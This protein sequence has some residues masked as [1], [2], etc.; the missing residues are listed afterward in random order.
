MQSNRRF[1]NG[2][3]VALPAFHLGMTTRR[4]LTMAV[5]GGRYAVCRLPADSPVP[6]WASEGW[7]GSEFCS[8]TRTPDELSIICPEARTPADVQAE[9]GFRVLKVEG[10]LAFSE[11]GIIAGIAV[12]LAAEGISLLAFS[13]FDSDYILVR[14]DSLTRAITALKDAGIGVRQAG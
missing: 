5:R 14:E 11:V 6:G 8:V 10:P 3:A 12:P 9:R 4:V 2:P 7:G 13:T 1:G